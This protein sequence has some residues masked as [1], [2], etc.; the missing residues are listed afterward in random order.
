MLDPLGLFRKK[1]YKPIRERYIFW[2]SDIIILSFPKSGRTWLRVLMG[3]ALQEHLKCTNDLLPTLEAMATASYPSVPNFLVD[4]GIATTQARSDIFDVS[5]VKYKDKKVILLVRDPKDV[6]VSAYFHKSKLKK[7]AFNASFSDFLRDDVG[8]LKTYLAFLNSWTN[9]KDISGY[10][11]IRYEEMHSDP[12][13]VLRSIFDFADVKDIS[14]ESLTAAIEFGR[15]DNMRELEKSD[16]LGSDRLRPVD[17]NDESTYKTRKG[18]VGSFVE[19][20]SEDDLAYA[21]SLI[22]GLNSIFGY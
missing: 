8:S 6:V 20:F 9:T 11:I 18:E 10:L 2:H 4:H 22:K 17:S 14:N 1:I 5:K 3:N 15:F 19:H 21:N 12:L 13:A 7:M 16:A